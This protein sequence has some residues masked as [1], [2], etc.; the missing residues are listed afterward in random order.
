MYKALIFKEWL[1]TR[2]VFIV[3]L[4]AAL[5]VALYVILSM[6]SLIA[7]NGVCALWLAMIIKDASFVDAVKYLPLI[8][9]IAMGVAQMAPE[10]SHKRLK[11]T[12]HLP[13][14]QMRLVAIMLAAGLAQLI[15]IYIVQ[16]AAIAIYDATILTP[17]LVGRVMLTMLPWYLAGLCAY[18]FVSAICLEG[19]WYTRIIL[20]LIGIAVMMIMFLQSGTMAAYNNMIITIIVLIVILTVLSFGSIVR[21]KEGLQD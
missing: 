12:L 4:I 16:A 2:R 21:F 19:T 8:I 10:M 15:I 11:L 6:N 20:A 7:A 5:L 18:L 14:P 3:S 13:Y 17:G 1:K 9:G